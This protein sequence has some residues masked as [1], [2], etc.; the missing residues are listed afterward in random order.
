VGFGVAKHVV[1]NTASFHPGNDGF[2][3]DTDTGD[4]PVF[5]FLFGGQ[6]ATSG[7]LLRNIFFMAFYLV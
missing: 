7:F 3:Q 6:F 1:N 4:H 5:C 2:N